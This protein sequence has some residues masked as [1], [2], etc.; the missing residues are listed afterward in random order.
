MCEVL[1]NLLG[2]MRYCYVSTVSV[3]LEYIFYTMH[4]IKHK[5]LIK[6]MKL[7]H[8][9]VL[10]VRGALEQHFGSC[11]EITR[12]SVPKDYDTGEIK[13]FVLFPFLSFMLSFICF[14]DQINWT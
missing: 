6:S 4:F 13:G 8:V 3:V 2:W 10:Q 14:K 7:Q 9:S 11:G 1:I 5:V 12:L